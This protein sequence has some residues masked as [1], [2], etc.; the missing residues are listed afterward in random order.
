MSA[1]LDRACAADDSLLQAG[2]TCWRAS[3]AARATLLVDA[4]EYFTALRAALLQARRQILIAG[5]DFDTR[6]RLPRGHSEPAH[7]DTAPQE[8]GE[9]LGYILRRR[10]EMEIHVVRWD[11]HW[12]YSDDREANTRARLTRLGVHFHDDGTH[13]VTGCVHHKVVVVD[14]ALAFCGG[15]DLTHK[16][17]D[18]SA[19]EVHEPRR[20]DPDD[21][22]YIPVHDTQLCVSGPV[23]R[24][25]HDYLLAGWPS[26]ERPKPVSDAPEL[27]P[28]GLRVE[29]R[30][31][32]VGIARTLPAMG[33]RQA[34][35]EIE[36]F[37]ARAIASAE[38]SLY[39]ENQYFTSTRIAQALAARLR[40]RPQLQG[41]LVGMDRP[42]THAERQTMGY[43]R[44]A[45]C[46]VLRQAGVSDRA[47][48]VA[49]FAGHLGI[50]L[51]S[52]LAVFDD[53][54]LV[55]GSANLNRRSMGFDVE[56]NLIIEARHPAERATIEALRNRLLAEHTG[57]TID[58]VC[59]ILATHGLARLPDHAQGS[60]RLVRVDPRTQPLEPSLGPILAPIFDPEEPWASTRSADSA[61]R[62]S[63]WIGS[64]LLVGLITAAL[65][66][67]SV[68]DDRLSGL[69]GLQQM[70]SSIL[71]S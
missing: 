44:S 18:T 29:F 41:L 45:F 19:H 16:R 9:L 32:R 35:R 20:T 58:A 31:V 43:G 13:P 39:L 15:I 54:W 61:P 52:K 14:G 64:L 47:P 3:A 34:S 42:K 60:R 6:T 12:F 57:L 62:S 2:T 49:A 68:V 59:A 48:L 55:V 56:C 70:L 30:D 51:H 26:A 25:L 63:R 8:L 46:D 38:R 10:P 50:N 27:W 24:D 1:N 4:D 22:P 40:A 67:G 69:S 37:Y 66:T 53:R 23:A 71:S 11:Y 21:G 5:W 65:L 36:A 7:R 28:H 33:A 17:W